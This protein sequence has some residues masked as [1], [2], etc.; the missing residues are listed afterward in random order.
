MGK[1]RGSIITIKALAQ[2]KVAVKG[3]RKIRKQTRWGGGVLSH[4][5]AG[6]N[7][8]EGTKGRCAHGNGRWELQ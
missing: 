6:F 2:G 8:H 1:E 3:A 5:R 7:A 4:G